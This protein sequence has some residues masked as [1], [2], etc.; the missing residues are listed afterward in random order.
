MSHPHSPEDSIIL[1]LGGSLVVPNGGIDTVF[2][3][4]FNTLVRQY[5]KNGK[6]FFIIV[7]GGSTCRHYQ[8]AAKTVLPD[9][10][11]EDLDW[12]G[13]HT[14]RLN[15]HLVRTI[16]RDIARP[17]VFDRYDRQ[18][19]ISRYSIL[20]GSGWR[21][22]FSTDYDAVYLSK[23]YGAKLFINMSNIDKVYTADPRKDPSATPIDH[24]SWNEYRRMVGDSW[25]PGLSTPFDPVASKLASEIGLR[26]VI[27]NGAKLDNLRNAIDGKPFVGTTIG[28]TQTSDFPIP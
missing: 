24:I 7:G 18:E 8:V 1:S 21:P 27:L 25:S 15:A 2:L 20:I 13:I 19:T 22:G 9:V 28:D 4:E 23:Q 11:D 3:S 17:R 5:V 14:T 16:F 10:P 26:V 12:L 6:R